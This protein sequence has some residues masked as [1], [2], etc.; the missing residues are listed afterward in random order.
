MLMIACR[1]PVSQDSPSVA[2]LRSLGC[3][4]LGKTAMQEVGI[5]PYGVNVR[6]G[7]SRN[8]QD[9]N[10]ICGG[11]SNGSAAVVAAGVCPIALG[12]DGGGS[13]RVPA[14]L[15]G[16][17]GLKPTHGRTSGRAWGTHQGQGLY[18]FGSSVTA[19]LANTSWSGCIRG[20]LFSSKC[21]KS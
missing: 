12:T 7:I 10:R 18:G 16:V 2:A 8:P 21:I 14:S 19:S 20:M 4:C 17:V 13:I 5:M 15:C 1:R 3:I 11:S 9:V 6:Q